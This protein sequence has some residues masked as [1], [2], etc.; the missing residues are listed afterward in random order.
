MT[1][2]GERLALASV[3]P[4]NGMSMSWR[5]RR[6]HVTR[7]Y[8]RLHI[9]SSAK[10]VQPL[11]FLL[12]CVLSC[13]ATPQVSHAEELVIVDQGKSEYRIVVGLTASIQD[14][15]AAE[16]L[17]THIAE[18]TGVTLQIVSDDNALVE[19]EIVIGFNQHFDAL[20]TGIARD[21]FNPEAFQI[22]TVGRRLIIVGGAPRGVLYG[23][24][25]VLTDEWG[26]R[27]FTPSLRKIPRYEQLKLAEVD[28]S[29]DPPFEYRDAWCFA[30]R[31]N[32]WAF[33]NFQNKDFAQLQPEQ[34]HRGGFS[35]SYMV[36]TIRRLVPPEK[37]Q[38]LH[39]D[40]FW[41]GIDDQPRSGRTTT[42]NRRN[43]LGACLT[44]PDVVEIAA[45]SILRLRR[46]LPEGD[47]HYSVSHSDFDDWCSPANNLLHL[48]LQ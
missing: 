43:W 23:V 47:V 48:C 1:S 38:E 46:V 29:Y 11:M 8:L 12:A 19:N 37:Y 4:D 42:Q 34:G 22:K 32:T 15:H 35:H 26:C 3:D 10:I 30:G 31:N 33:H 20:E 28:R 13:F 16:V 14:Y 25:S 27:W 5:M 36:H 21:S 2:T 7:L 24:N 6:G 9:P 18:M 44:H 41:K 45:A 40:Y 39:P 17:Q